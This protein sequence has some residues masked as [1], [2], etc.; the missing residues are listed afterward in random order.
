MPS[1]P[2][3]P[4]TPV[5]TSPGDVRPPKAQI[6]QNSYL[7]IVAYALLLGL[8]M[9]INQSRVGHV[10]LYYTLLIMI[11][12]V[13]VTEYSRLAPLFIPLDLSQTS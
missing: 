7:Y 4:A 11:L 1:A 9:L 8:C 5:P 13:V 12:F 6:E 2:H 10:L 3:T